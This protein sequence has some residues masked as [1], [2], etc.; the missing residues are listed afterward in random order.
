MRGNDSSP[1]PTENPPVSITRTDSPL[2][3]Q[4]GGSPMPRI[5]PGPLDRHPQRMSNMTTNRRHG[6]S[7]CSKTSRERISPVLRFSPSYA[8]PR[9]RRSMSSHMWRRINPYP[10][11]DSSSPRGVR[12]LDS[13]SDTS[14]SRSERNTSGQRVSSTV[15]HHNFLRLHLK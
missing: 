4:S 13:P 10:L 9:T 3:P 1:H 11:C 12:R 6:Q 14:C 8:S 2:R 5:Q 15:W 7:H